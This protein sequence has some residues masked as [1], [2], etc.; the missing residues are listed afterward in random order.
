MS[1]LKMTGFRDVVIH[2]YQEMNME[3]LR[4]IAEKEHTS[5]VDLCSEFGISIP[6]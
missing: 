1:G 2:E 4:A 3:I 6:N 5:L